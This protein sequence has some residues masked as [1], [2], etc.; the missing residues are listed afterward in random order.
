M[1]KYEEAFVKFVPVK[2]FKPKET[3]SKWFNKDIKSM[4]RRKNKIWFR[5]KSSGFKNSTLQKGA[6]EDSMEL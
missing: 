5:L 4:S 3:N 6:K 2:Q 1:N